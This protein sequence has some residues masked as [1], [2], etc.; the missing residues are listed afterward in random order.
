[1]STQGFIRSALLLAAFATI[2][3]CGGSSASSSSSAAPASAVG[4]ASLGSPS[5][6]VK[7]TDSLDFEPASITAKVG[8][9]VQWTNTGTMPHN[10]TFDTAASADDT[11]FGPGNTWEV[12]FS[13]PGTYKYQCTTHPGMT[14]TITVTQ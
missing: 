5:Q 7:A 11:A 4:G 2:A 6:T 1:M 3:A 14:G 12:K 9:V 10:I 13:Q 8:D